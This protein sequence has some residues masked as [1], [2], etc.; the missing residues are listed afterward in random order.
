MKILISE[1]QYQKIKNIL[2]ENIDIDEITISYTKEPKLTGD[3]K[4]KYDEVKS[5]NFKLKKFG[6][7]SFYYEIDDEYDSKTIRINILDEEK[8]EY[9]GYAAF[10]II[11]GNDFKVNYPFI[12]PEY[13]GQGISTEI[14]RTVLHNGNLISGSE[15]TLSAIGLWKK[16]YRLFP[17]MKFI[18]GNGKKHDVELKNDEFVTKDGIKIH[19]NNQKEKSFLMIPKK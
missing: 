5:T 19:N 15:Q 3:F 6:K 12:R 14:Y 1:K 8:K 2:L 4:K 7:F 10:D 11:Y 9:V 18:D 17:D 13:R 16:L